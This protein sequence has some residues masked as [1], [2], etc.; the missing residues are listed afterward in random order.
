MTKREVGG[1]V[2]ETFMECHSYERAMELASR[3]LSLSNELRQ[4]DRRNLDDAVFE[5]LGVTSAAERRSLLDRL[6]TETAS[7]FRAI[8]ITEIQKLVDRAGGERQRF[9]AS[10]QAADAWDALDLTDLI[11]LADWVR[12]NARG[13]TQE[14][15]IAS[16]RPAHLDSQNMFDRDTVYFGKKRQI[17]T[18]CPTRGTAELLFRMATLGVSGSHILPVEHQEATELLE[19]LNERQELA[20]GKFAALVA[21]RASDPETQEQML[22][23]LVRWFVLGRSLGTRSGLSDETGSGIVLP[24]R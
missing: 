20:E 8:R 23:V 12:T 4:E 5:L 18:V 7:H 2:D 13:I 1:L 6:Y 15:S 24:A 21:S 3:P 10:E 11:P 22:S 16:E 17:H 14:F 9:T 19:K